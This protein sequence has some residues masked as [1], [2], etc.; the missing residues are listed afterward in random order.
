MNEIFFAFGIDS[1]LLFPAIGDSTYDIGIYVF[2]KA[3]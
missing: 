2:S 1:T 3:S